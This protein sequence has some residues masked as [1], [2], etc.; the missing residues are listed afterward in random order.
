MHW[1]ADFHAQ[2]KFQQCNEEVLPVP[3]QQCVFS[4]KSCC[5][6]IAE[7]LFYKENKHLFSKYKYLIY[8]ST[9]ISLNIKNR[10]IYCQHKD[11][12]MLSEAGLTVLERT[13]IFKQEAYLRQS[14]IS[15]WY[16]AFLDTW[17]PGRVRPN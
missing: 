17:W 11:C 2:Y 14:R 8:L 3:T 12:C 7:Y 5:T 16:M 1:H 9:S 4:I 6:D 13:L 10:F 15:C